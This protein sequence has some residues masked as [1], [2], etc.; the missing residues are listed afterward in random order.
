MDGK[1]SLSATNLA[2]CQHLNC[3]LYIHN[4]Y[5]GSRQA[6]STSSPESELTKAQ[7]KRGLDWETSLYSWLDRS[8][9][10]LKVP[11]MPLEASSLLENIQ[12]D[13]RAHFFIT[14]LTFWPPQAKLAE[15]FFA[16][17]RTEP[18]N[19]G[20]AKPDLLE[21][22]RSKD[23]VI[24]WRVLD[25][26][27]SKHVKVGPYFVIQRTVFSFAHFFYP[28][29]SHHIQ[30]YF[31]T[32]C[33]KHLLE[34]PLYQAV[35]SAGIWL[36]PTNGFHTSTPSLEDIK[37]ISISLLAPAFDTFLFEE[38]PRILSQRYE[39]VKWHYNPLCHGCKYEPE[40]RPRVQKEGGLGSMPNIS[41][42]DARVLKD[43]LRLSHVSAP[44]DSDEK[45]TDIEQLHDLFAK[46]RKLD[47]ISGRSPVL[48]KKSKQIL[49]VSRKRMKKG[50][51]LSPPVEAARENAIQ[52]S[53]EMPR[54]I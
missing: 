46:P 48:V 29:T 24:N 27:A 52:V 39:Q 8:K 41:I 4:V 35:D 16:R 20:L 3:D 25:A 32:L 43:L 30:I 50:P 34:H 53:S 2:V 44:F 37:S 51:L 10:L 19:F 11:S 47:I 6:V 36:P 23:G 31:Y 33:L 13:D 22:K 9:L 17:A 42:D 40:C 28:Q 5:N 14:G 26:K 1:H 18:F 15:I 54:H 49:G 12:A 7:C 21:I 45:L 38:L